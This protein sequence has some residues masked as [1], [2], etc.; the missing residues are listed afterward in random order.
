MK[1]GTGRYPL[2]EKYVYVVSLAYMFGETADS[3][4][5][6]TA[7]ACLTFEDAVQHVLDI[8]DDLIHETCDCMDYDFKQ[9]Y[10]ISANVNAE[11]FQK[12]HEEHKA[13]YNRSVHV[14]VYNDPVSSVAMVMS[15][16]KVKLYEGRNQNE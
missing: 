5:S 3:I 14:M 10:M 9:K 13:S 4:G 7:G 12:I 6:V 11:V 8:A 1:E 15:I 16:T 2:K